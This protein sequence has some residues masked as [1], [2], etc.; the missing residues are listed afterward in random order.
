MTARRVIH[1]VAPWA[2]ALAAGVSLLLPAV[3]PPDPVV[4]EVPPLEVPAPLG[5]S[6]L[7]A[8]LLTTP[9]LPPD[10]SSRLPP[11]LLTTPP[12]P[13]DSLLLPPD[14]RRVPAV[15]SRPPLSSPPVCSEPAV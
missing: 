4:P 5:S 9:P 11:E 14:P 12:L 13:P 2:M 3:A 1:G 7:P 6:R 8:E 10:S 15:P